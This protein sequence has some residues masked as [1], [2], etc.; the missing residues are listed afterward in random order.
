MGKLYFRKMEGG[1]RLEMRGVAPILAEDRVPRALA[2]LTSV[3]KV[4]SLITGVIR[5]LLI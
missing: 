3:R 5:S 1:V 2:D 4:I